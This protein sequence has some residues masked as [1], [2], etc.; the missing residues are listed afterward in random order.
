MCAREC[1]ASL[2]GESCYKFPADKGYDDDMSRKRSERMRRRRS[3]SFG[4][5]SYMQQSSHDSSGSCITMTTTINQRYQSPTP[6]ATIYYS[7][8]NM[9]FSRRCIPLRR[10]AHFT[11][12]TGRTLSWESSTAASCCYT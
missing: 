2:C 7:Q 6:V 11:T 5:D 4:V 9:I 8:T 10:E 1:G 3:I 12:P